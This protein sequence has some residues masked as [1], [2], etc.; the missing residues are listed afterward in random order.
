MQLGMQSGASVFPGVNNEQAIEQLSWQ[1]RFADE[2]GFQ[3]IWLVEH[4]FVDF[5]LSG[6]PSTVL[7]HYA[8]I[9]KNI[10]IGYAVAVVPLHHPVRLAEE[11]AW[12]DQLSHGRLMAGIG[13]GFS[14]LEYGVFGVDVD[15]KREYVNEA[16]E[17]LQR[18]LTGETFTYE[19]EIYQIP[20]VRIYPASYQ[21]RKIPFYMATS[22]DDSVARAARW[23]I[24]PL[25]GFRPN[26][27]LVR[28]IALYRHVR[29][30][31]G[32]TKE[33]IDRKQKEIGVLRRIVV[34]DSEE[35][36]QSVTNAGSLQFAESIRRL[37]TASG[38]S[39][40]RVRETL[41]PDG[42][43]VMLQVSDEEARQ[44]SAQNAASGTIAGTKSH[45]IEQLYELQE[46]GVGHVLG[47]FGGRGVPHAEA[48]ANLEMVASDILP[49]FNS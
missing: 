8:T 22:S 14:P 23:D 15:R 43:K 25:L 41:L 21:G 48:R 27:I 28:Q 47:G 10:K 49:L 24:H 32:D 20:E 3:R 17:I 1:A 46:T 38:E 19:G 39:A 37:N 5:A 26:D 30:E 11:M 33:E 36:A 45:V 34:A 4:H 2:A 7:A 9:T 31:M 13:P 42:R 16:F 18:A 35:E 29:E 12:V 40:P 44:A 6:A